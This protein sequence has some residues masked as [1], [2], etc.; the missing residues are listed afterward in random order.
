MSWLNP[1]KVQRSDYN[2]EA[3]VE[4]FLQRH[5][6]FAT[7]VLGS[8]DAV[9]PLRCGEIPDEYLGYCERFV[10]N[11]PKAQVASNDP[12]ALELFVEV[13]RRTFSANQ[14]AESWVTRETIILIA[15]KIRRQMLAAKLS[16]DTSKW[17]ENST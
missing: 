10:E 11:L 15:E 2:P 8:F 16:L 12:E 7:I 6:R 3:K 4:A 5:G 9:D 1:S 14:V 17:P 13:V